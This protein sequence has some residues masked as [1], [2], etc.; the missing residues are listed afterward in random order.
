MNLQFNKTLI[1]HI[2]HAQKYNI[3]TKKGSITHKMNIFM[4]FLYK[5]SATCSFTIF[6]PRIN[7][8]GE[9]N[10]G[11]ACSVSQYAPVRNPV[12]LKCYNRCVI[13]EKLQHS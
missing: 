5:N 6:W 2:L 1:K 13:S 3:Y 8:D 7:S 10:Y 9:Q 4:L 11:F 12:H